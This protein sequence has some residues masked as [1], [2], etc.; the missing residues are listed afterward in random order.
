MPGKGE[1]S[2]G[3]LFSELTQELRTLF[4]QEMELFTV[5]MKEKATH[6]ARDAVAI[7]VGGV[8]IYSGFLVLLAAIV[9]GVATFMPAWGGALLVAT[10]FIALGFI[11]VQKGR[12]DLTQMEMKPEKTTE[13]LKETAQWAKTL[14]S[15]SSSPRRTS[16]ASRSDTRRAI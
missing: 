11:L 4:R 9:L 13:S 8:M 10:A 16:Y 3:E 2:I 5:E 7:G 6:A 15:P 12:K 14:R 1:R